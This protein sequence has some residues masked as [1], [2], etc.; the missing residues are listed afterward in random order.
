MNLGPTVNTASDDIMPNISADGSVLYFCSPRPGGQ[1]MWDIYQAPI[2]PVVDLNAD[3]LVDTADMCVIIDHWGTDNS[4]CDI[5]P[6][7]WGDGM[8]DVKDLR[9]FMI[10]WEQ[11]NMPEQPDGEQ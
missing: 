4:L 11:E 5:G 1:G 8:V 10:Y 9:V 2:I 7:P 3:G 6:M